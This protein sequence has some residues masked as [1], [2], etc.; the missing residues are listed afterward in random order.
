MLRP[1][2]TK[3]LKEDMEERKAARFWPWQGYFGYN[4]KSSGNKRKNE[5]VRLHE[6]KKL[7][8]VKGIINTMK[9]QPMD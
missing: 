1:E 3:L 5:H 2:I 8:T 7:K 6:M 4:P 9:K